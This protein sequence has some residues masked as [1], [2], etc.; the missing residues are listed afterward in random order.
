MILVVLVVII[1]TINFVAATQS[2]AISIMSTC[3]AITTTNSIMCG[4]SLVSYE[5]IMLAINSISTCLL[6]IISTHFITHISYSAHLLTPINPI[7]LI[8]IP[9]NPLLVSQS[10]PSL[11]LNSTSSSSTITHTITIYFYYCSCS[12]YY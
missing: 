8:L 5:V 10:L 9:I 11:S 7:L 2:F 12:C 6:V 1:S 4:S 3:A